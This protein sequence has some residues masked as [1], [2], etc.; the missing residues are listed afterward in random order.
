VLYTHSSDLR[1]MQNI[2]HAGPYLRGVANANDLSDL[3]RPG[4]VPKEP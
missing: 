3:F 1:T 2:F 4:A